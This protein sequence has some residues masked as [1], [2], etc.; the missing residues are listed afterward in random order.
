M[1]LDELREGIYAID[2]TVSYIVYC[3]SGQSS[4]AAAFLLHERGI[5]AVPLTAGI[6]DW[7]Y[8]VD[9]TPR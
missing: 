9:S 2:P 4:K 3:R 7:P 1:P 6:K 5:R 8:E